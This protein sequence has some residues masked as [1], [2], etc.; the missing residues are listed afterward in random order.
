MNLTDNSIK[1]PELYQCIRLIFNFVFFL[2]VLRVFV[3]VGRLRRVWRV[4]TGHVGCIRG[5]TSVADGT[6]F[7]RDQRHGLKALQHQRLSKSSVET[8]TFVRVV[9]WYEKA[10][11]EN[12]DDNHSNE[13]LV[14]DEMFL[15]GH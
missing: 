11:Y 13:L 10:S 4:H 3:A 7:K 15:Y 12:T 6:N 14:T 8:H 9:S 2:S 5:L 1:F